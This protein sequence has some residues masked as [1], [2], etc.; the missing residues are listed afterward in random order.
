MTDVAFD[1]NIKEWAGEHLVIFY[2]NGP[3]ELRPEHL[4]IGAE[5]LPEKWELKEVRHWNQRI[6]PS[7]WSQ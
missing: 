6:T 2:W 1:Y 5:M 4:K 3:Y 7:S